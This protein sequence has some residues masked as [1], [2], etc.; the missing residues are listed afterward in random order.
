MLRSESLKEMATKFFIVSF[1]RVSKTIYRSLLNYFYIFF[2]SLNIFVWNLKLSA[3][4]DICGYARYVTTGITQF[5]FLRHNGW[6][7]LITA[8]TA[9]ASHVSTGW[10]GFKQYLIVGRYLGVASTGLPC[11]D[12]TKTLLFRLKINP[13]WARVRWF[14]WEYLPK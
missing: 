11:C 4:F 6:H 8:C 14:R 2:I 13:R 3:I 10:E 7:A 9:S 1:E 5:F 12:V